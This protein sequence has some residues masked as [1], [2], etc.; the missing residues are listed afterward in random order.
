MWRMILT[1]AILLVVSTAVLTVA[2][3]DEADL[4][5]ELWVQM[6]GDEHFAT[7]ERATTRLVEIGSSAKQAVVQGVQ[8]PDREI[9]Y[10]CLR[11]L[12]LIEENDFQRRL[13]AFEAGHDDEHDLPG[14]PRYREQFGDQADS[15][16]FFVEMLKS[17][18]DL[19]QSIDADPQAVSRI[20]E[21]RCFQIQQTQNVTRQPVSLGSIAAMLFA[22]S[23]QQVRVHQTSGSTLA[24]LCYQPEIQNAMYDTAR[25][26]IVR[27]LLGDWIRRND[28]W[29]AFQNL[30]L[31]MRY[32][33]REGLVAAKEILQNPGNQP[34][35]RQNA[36][37]A[38]VK[39]GDDQEIPLLETLL[40]DE[41][42][43]A[44]Q[45]IQD[46]TYETQLRDVALAAILMIEGKDPKEFG[47]DRIQRHDVNVF[48]TG[49]IGFADPD[50]RDQ[51]LEK[52]RK[53][54]GDPRAGG[55]QP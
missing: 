10:R 13:A 54:R 53:S 45:R 27:Q 5:V 25:R 15:R 52:F 11:I 9:R 22:V 14:W 46:T 23:D 51:A 12:A 19:M 21:S 42:R 31:A 16:A 50:Q 8:H 47:F 20:L 18:P 30:A 43:C 34:Y 7:R 2:A 6:L 35:I 29:A 26:P 41:S 49:T 40:D 55:E 4:T 38:I 39:L 32:E 3:A 36:I 37:L 1:P 44:I 28:R 17:E 24:T 33:M 48:I